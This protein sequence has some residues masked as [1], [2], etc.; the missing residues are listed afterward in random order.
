M[1]HSAA[2]GTAAALAGLYTLHRIGHAS[3]LAP[4]EAAGP[5]P[6]DELVADPKWQS[7]RAITVDAP[8]ERLWPWIV[9]MGFPAQRAGW[10]TPHWLDR[11]T[12]GIEE[13]SADRIVPEL[14]HL[15]AGDR[16][17][18]SLDGSAY[19]TAAQVEPP[20]ALVL[21]STRHLI[22]PV[23]TIDFSWAFVIRGLGP[24]RSRLLIRARVDYT[25]R[26]ALP[27]VELVVGPADFVNAGSMLRGIKRRA[28]ADRSSHLVDLGEPRFAEPVGREER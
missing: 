19:F 23:R 2:S 10:Y 26:W 1:R 4:V 7:T 3:G 17:P 12:F 13:R 27:F 11:L 25:P 8:P 6:G 28:E 5:L 18:D 24:G 15:E 14:Q 9:Q 20:H 16:V 21:H 22:K